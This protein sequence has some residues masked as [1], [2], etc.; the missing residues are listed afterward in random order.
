MCISEASSDEGAFI[1]SSFSKMTFLL[2]LLFEK[3]TSG[4]P[5]MGRGLTVFFGISA[6]VPH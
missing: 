6:G 4:F 5:S 1:V 3:L 2:E